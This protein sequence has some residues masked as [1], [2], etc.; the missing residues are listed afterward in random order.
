M[1]LNQRSDFQYLEGVKIPCTSYTENS[2]IYLKVAQQ[3]VRDVYVKTCQKNNPIQKLYFVTLIE[4]LI[5]YLM[6]Y[7]AKISAC[8]LPSLSKYL[9]WENISIIRSY[10]NNKKAGENPISTVALSL[11]ICVTGC[12]CCFFSFYFVSSI[13]V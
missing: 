9:M 5:K 2:R 12:C 1:N 6:V 4:S 10:N 3:E 11:K 7:Q 13:F 8:L